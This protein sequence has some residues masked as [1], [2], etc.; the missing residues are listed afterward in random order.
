MELTWWPLTTGIEQYQPTTI[1]K[2]QATGWLDYFLLYFIGV[3]VAIFIIGALFGG[4][5]KAI[6]N[7]TPRTDE[8]I[9]KRMHEANERNKRIRQ[10]NEY[11]SN[12]K[13]NGK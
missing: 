7:P 1:E 8:Q 6:R 3:V 11:I 2:V 9:A 10:E 5:K 12:P 4:A 13:K